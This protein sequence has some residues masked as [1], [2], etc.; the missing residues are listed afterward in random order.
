MTISASNNQTLSTPKEEVSNVTVMFSAYG[1]NITGSLTL[2][3]TGAK[4]LSYLKDVRLK[5]HGLISR[6]TKGRVYNGHGDKVT[7][8]YVPKPGELIVLK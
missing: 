2:R 4:L 7:A 8:S 6:A 1:G 3:H 5:K